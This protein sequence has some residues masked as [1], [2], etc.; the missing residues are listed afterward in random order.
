MYPKI[1]HPLLSFQPRFADHYTFAVGQR[2]RVVSRSQ[3]H[4]LNPVTGQ[5]VDPIAVLFSLLLFPLLPPNF[6]IE[7]E[8]KAKKVRR[9][10]TV[11]QGLAWG[12]GR[13]EREGEAHTRKGWN[14]GTK[15]RA[16]RMRADATIWW[17]LRGSPVSTRPSADQY[18]S[19]HTP[20]HTRGTRM[21]RI[22]RTV[23]RVTLCE[24]VNVHEPLCT[25]VSGRIQESVNFTWNTGTRGG[26]VHARSTF[27][28]DLC[29]LHLSFSL[30]P[31]FHFS[32]FP[33]LVPFLSPEKFSPLEGFGIVSRTPATILLKCNNFLPPSF[34]F[35]TRNLDVC[36]GYIYMY[37]SWRVK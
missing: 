21:S 15:A 7:K 16:R 26:A 29:S 36:R 30:V 32:S 4:L 9:A 17:I 3:I 20:R 8:K 11:W 35:A 28:L 22:V 33:I 27:P 34:L 12:G 37:Y 25:R 6:A 19:A 13:G 24:R 1:N 23:T 31:I 10:I 18:T 2:T 5:P 14:E